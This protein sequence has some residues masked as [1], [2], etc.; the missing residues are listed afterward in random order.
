MTLSINQQIPQAPVAALAQPQQGEILPTAILKSIHNF[1]PDEPSFPSTCRI[2]ST[3]LPND[4]HLKLHP[5]A[6][7]A[8]LARILKKYKEHNQK[9]TS[10]DLYYCRNITNAGLKL[11]SNLP[12]TRLNLHGCDITDAGLVHLKNLPLTHL[13]LS[14]CHKINGECLAYLSPSLT[15]LNL[16]GTSV[17]SA[18][19]SHLKNYSYLTQLTLATCRHI[20]DSDLACLKDLPLTH[21]DIYGYQIT[22]K[23][24]EN[25]SVLPLQTLKIGFT[26]ITNEGLTFIAK[27]PLTHLIIN[28]TNITNDGLAIIG[29]IT[30]L[31][32]LNLSHSKNITSEGLEHLRHLSS[33]KELLLNLNRNIIGLPDLMHLSLRSLSLAF[34]TQITDEGLNNLCDCAWLT[35]LNLHGCTKVTDTGLMRLSQLPLKTFDIINTGASPVLHVRHGIDRTIKNETTKS[36]ICNLITEYAS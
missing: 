23:A 13:D 24:L 8:D 6:T 15:H 25:L 14:L 5:S 29:K 35:D 2:W 19:L 20:A 10:V 34:C 36:K 3:L 12:L 32:H 21:L 27:L 30:S 33:L 17:T 4:G 16:G 31:T 9:I 28:A 1:I 7:D 26:G 22:D 18:L 11:L